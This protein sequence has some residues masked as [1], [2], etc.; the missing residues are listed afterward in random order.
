MTSFNNF[1]IQFKVF[2]VNFFMEGFGYKQTKKL[3]IC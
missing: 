2:D 1:M 3:N